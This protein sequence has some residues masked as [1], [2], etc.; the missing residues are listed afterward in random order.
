MK[1]LY[2][3]RENRVWKGV[4]GGFGEYFNIDPVLLR[5]IFILFVLI[6]GIFP[7]VIA[8]I[9][10][11]FIVPESPFQIPKETVKVK[12]EEVKSEEVKKEN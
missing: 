7:G 2:R 3:S 12:M 4:L 5:V 10:A 9:I 1:K 8:Y 6:S 11:I